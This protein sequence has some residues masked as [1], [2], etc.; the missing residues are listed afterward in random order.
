[1]AAK[2]RWNIAQWFELRWWKQYL[3]NKDTTAYLNWKQQ[4]WKKVLQQLEPELLVRSHMSVAD[5]GCGPSGIYMAV[6]ECKVTAID[7]LLDAYEKNTA[8]FNKG[9]Y[10]HVQFISTTL[11]AYRP[12]Q[13]FDVVFCMNAI[14]HVNNYEQALNTL[15]QCS[16]P[17]GNVAITIDAHN[18]RFFKYLFRL[19]PGD[20]LHPHQFDLNEY[21]QHLRQRHLRVIK[22]VE[23]KQGF[24]FNHY[25]LL[26]VNTGQ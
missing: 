13:P 6:K 15:Q 8:V 22:C 10:P 11:E 7:P 25:L 24:F 20:V 12:E 5:L 14:N 4:Y 19:I 9:M 17:G 21:K 23:L 2:W 3:K 26:A 1:M 18:H 16:K